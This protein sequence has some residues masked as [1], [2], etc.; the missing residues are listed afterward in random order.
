[1]WVFVRSRSRDDTKREKQM[2]GGWFIDI[3]KSKEYKQV[4][5]RRK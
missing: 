4:S 2:N 1:M 3:A 5:G